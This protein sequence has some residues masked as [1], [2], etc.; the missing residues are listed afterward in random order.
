MT[1][2]TINVLAR[3]LSLALLASTLAFVP[4]ISQVQAQSNPVWA[5]DGVPILMRGGQFNF[6]VPDPANPGELILDQVP[7]TSGI[8][9]ST[10]HDP[11]NGWVYGVVNIGGVRTVR[12]YDA[13]G[14][15]VFNTPIVGDYPQAAG[16]F[17]GTV[18]GDGRYIIHSVGAANGNGW[19]NGNRFNLWAIDPLTG[20]STFIGP[21]PVNFADFSYNP[22]DGFLYQ[23]V[24]RVLYRV[25]PNDGTTT[26]VPTSSVLPN[27]SFGA[28]WFD[29]AG[30][31]HVFRNADGSIWRIDPANPQN[32]V[33]V[34]EVGSN[35]GTDGTNCIS[36][37]DLRKDVVDAAGDAVL[38]QDRVYSVGDVVTYEFTLINNGLPTQNRTVD[39]CDVLPADG[40]VYTGDWTATDPT[41]TL[42]SGGAAGDTNICLEV[43]MPSSLWTDP[44]TPGSP[45]TVVTIDVEIGPGTTPGELQ[46]QATLD[47]DQDGTVDVRSDDPGDGSDPRDPT[48]IEV[49]GSFL[50]SKTVVGHPTDDDSDEFAMTISCTTAS[51]DPFDI[52]A[53]SIVDASTGAAWPGATTNG[54]TI[55][56]GD[57]V[58]VLGL[59]AGTSCTTTEAASTSY[60][61]TVAVT[62]GTPGDG[63]GDDATGAVSTGE[64]T[65][66]IINDNCQ[67]GDGGFV[68]FNL[69]VRNSSGN[70][71][72]WETIWRN[73]PYSVIPNLNAGNY[74]HSVIPAPG[75]L[76]DHVFT[77]TTP[78]GAFGNLAITG[79]VPDPLGSDQGCGDVENFG[80]VTGPASGGGDTGDGGATESNSATLTIDS[81]DESIA[82]TNSTST[83]AIRKGTSV[84]SDLPLDED[85]TFTFD[86][87]CSNGLSETLTITTSGGSDSI[88]Y[89]DTPLVG[90]GV[91]CT[92]S[93][94]VPN[95]WVLT[96]PND[97]EIET[98]AGTIA[99]ATFLNE[100]TFAD[101][102]ISK[103]I[104]GLP[105]GEDPTAFEFDLE[106]R[107]TGGFDPDPYTTSGTFAVGSPLIIEDLPVGAECTVTED[108]VDG[109]NTRYSPQQS[110][111]IASSG[112]DVQVTNSTGSLIIEK[113]TEVASTHPIDP[114]DDFEFTLTCSGPDGIFTDTYSVSADS[115]VADGATG[116]VSHTDV[117]V[118]APGTTC[119]VTETSPAPLWTIDGSDT[120]TLEITEADPEPTATFVNVRNVG[121]LVV[122]KEL[123]GVPA[124]VDLDSEEFI[125]DISCS[126]GFTVD[127][128]LI[129]GQTVSV[130]VP[131]VIDDL[132]TGAECTVTEQ[133]DPRFATTGSPTTVTIDD[134]GEDVLL[135]NTT[136]SFEF[137]KRTASSDIVGT[138]DG[139]FDFAITCTFD[140]VEVASTTTSLTTVGGIAIVDAAGLP[141]VPPGSTCTVTETVPS[142]W[143]ISRRVAPTL[144]GTDGIEF[145]TPLTDDV[146][147]ENTLETET[148]TITKDVLG[149]A[150]T[151]ALEGEVFTI[152][153]ECTGIFPGGT[154]SSG[155]LSISEGAPID[156]DGL[157]LGA[158]CTVAETADG[159]FATTYVPGDSLTIISGDNEVGVENETSTFT[160]SKATV[161]PDGVEPDATFDFAIECI[162]D[163]AAVYTDNITIST[164]AGVGAWDAAPFLPPGT[165]CTVTETAPA[166]WTSVGPGTITIT[167]EGDT[168]VDAAFT[169]E[170]DNADLTIT[171]TLLGDLDGFDFTNEPF[172]AEV[173]CTG[174]FETSPFTTTATVTATT[175]AV[176]PDLPVGAECSVSEVF[177]SRFQTL[178]APE[179]TAGDAAEVTIA[180]GGTEAGLINVAGRLAIRKNT[181]GP[182]SH[183]LGL[184]DDF[185]YTIDCTDGTLITEVANVD[186]L[187]GGQGIGG[188]TYTALPPFAIGTVCTIT[189]TVPPGWT[190]TTPN[191]QTVTIQTDLQTAEFTN[192]RDAGSLTINKTLDGVPTGVDLSNEPFTVT[193]TCTGGG[194]TT[195]PHIIADQIVT[196]S[197]PLVID[198]LPTGAECSA[199]EDSDPR[200]TN[201]VS[202]SV[203]I[204]TDGEV[205]DIV[206]TTSTFSITKTTIGPDTVPVILDDTFEFEVECTSA[207]GDVLFSGTESITT[208]GQTGS[209]AAPDTPLLA[210]GSEC[211]V[212]ELAPPAGW[213]NTSGTTVTITTDSTGSI[214]AA[215][216]NERDTDTLAVTKTITGSPTDLSDEAFIVDISC[217][218]DF[219]TSPHL[220]SGVTLTENTPIAIPDL[221]TGAAC[222][223][224]EQPDAR[225]FA[226]YSPDD[227]I[228][229][230]GE[231]G[232]LVDIDNR[233]GT[234]V[235]EKVV[236]VVGT[237]PIDLSGTFQV[238][239]SCTDGTEF[240]LTLDV[241][242][243]VTATAQ[244]PDVPLLPDGTACT[245]T[246]AGPPTG[247]TLTSG[248]GIEVIV[249]SLGEPVIS[250]TNTRDTGDLNITKT[251]LGAPAGLDVAS[252]TFTVDI[253]C[254]G[255]FTTSPL[256]LSDQPIVNGET[257]TIEDLPT[258]AVCTVIEDPDPRFATTT[259]PVD[260]P[261]TGVTI[262][263]DGED[264]ALVNATGEI[265]IVKNT[266]VS[267]GFP[268]DV[269]ESFDF[270]VDCGAVYSGTHTVVADTITSPTT[271]TG[272]LRYSD[273]PALPN[274]TDC[275]V[276]EQAA[277]TGWTLVSPNPVPLTVDSSGVVTAAF[278]NERDTGSLTIDKTLV[279]VPAITD[280][281]AELFDVTVTCAGGFTAATEVITGQISVDAPLVIPEL[282]T[283]SECAVVETPDARFTTSV[284]P[285][286]TITTDGEEIDVTNTTSTL[287][288]TKTTTGPA[289]QP[290]DLDDTFTFTVECTTATGD[291]LFSG[292]QT[293]TTVDQTGTWATP[294]TPLLPPGTECTISENASTGWTNTSG[295]T[296]TVTTESSDVVD[297]AFENV[298]DTGPLTINKALV[299]V[300]AGTDLDAELFDVTVTC[301]GDF[302]TTT[303]TITG[304][305]SVD[306]PLTITDLPTGATCT[307]I[308]STD[309]RFATSVDGPATIDTDG[310]DVE[311]TNATSTLSITKTTTGPTTHPLDLDDTFAFDTVCTTATGDI[312]FSGTQTITTVDQTG[313]WATP[314]TPLLPPGTECTVTEQTPPTGWTNTSGT[315][316]T[317]TTESSD[318]VDAAFIN[319]RDTETLT[320]NK[321]LLGVPE[322]I[323]LS[324]TPFD[325]TVTCTT[326]FTTTEHTVNGQVSSVAPLEIPDL[327]TGAECE[328]EEA[329]DARFFTTYT[330]ANDTGDAAVTTITNGEN[331]VQV[332]NSTGA[333][334]VSKDT[335]VPP[336]H[337]IDPV[338]EFT[339]TIDCGAVYSA[340]HT[341]T[342]DL[343]T[344]T[345]AT[346]VIFYTDLP[347]IPEGTI[348]NVTE[349]D[350]TPEWTLTTDRTVT[351][352]ASSENP[353]TAQFVNERTLGTLDINKII[354]GP[355]EVD[356][357]AET[358]DITVTCSNGFTEDPYVL[359]GVIGEGTPFTIDDLPYGAECDTAESAD[360][361]FATSYSS[362]QGEISSDVTITTEPSIVDVLNQTGSFHV[363]IGTLVSSARPFDPDDEF[364]F[365]VTCSNNDEVIYEAT[366]DATTEDG[367]FRFEAALLPTGTTCETTLDS[368]SEW[369]TVSAMGEQSTEMAITQ[370]I[371]TDIAWNAFEVERATASLP[372]NKE[373]AGLPA[374]TDFAT[375][376]FAI[377]VTCVGG[378]IDAEHQLTEDLLVSTTDPLIVPE[379][380]V[381]SEC[382][383]VEQASDLFDDSYST[384]PTFVVS[385]GDSDNALII[386]NT[387]TDSL[388]SSLEPDA[389]PLAFTGSTVWPLV[390]F[391]ILLLLAGV[392]IIGPRRRRDEIEA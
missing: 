345:G 18:L 205:I 23:P 132:P 324:A 145:T 89:P 69:Q 265:M 91:T 113:F 341:I 123:A 176:V 253:V 112:T 211:T 174:D 283:G 234:F 203:T 351:L 371:G 308:E 287:S 373:L 71:I 1:S 149:V 126:G 340:D 391:A 299:G 318:I 76:F 65:A 97:V 106:V 382:T 339:F 269:T 374:D 22:L 243:G 329:S 153:V 346:G 154:Y 93:E 233:T 147:F 156:I 53:T 199:V 261:T 118:I 343:L 303:H 49:L 41:A 195:D 386:T 144:V 111:E 170:R 317:V 306:S 350:E 163:G 276:T 81:G 286:A 82:F 304:Q 208:L 58:E 356:L 185:T 207:T 327:P 380:P 280:L 39:L 311:I 178:Y 245:A 193:V 191:P 131:L 255:D 377:D 337:P 165:V 222:T 24:N 320:V 285:D 166:G 209:W 392:L 198:D 296:A 183:P 388:L 307:A 231:N 20:A 180:D 29:S 94:D 179:N 128:Y 252:L 348:C 31:L 135:T 105:D 21:T 292:T 139:T 130:A 312:L 64:P 114:V 336:T 378:F 367:A 309:A 223:V 110:V 279:G 115:L 26:T 181:L 108:P 210:P 73:R 368:P 372:I 168:V 48:T 90:D 375:E 56:N 182:A 161:V 84:T 83:L 295:I 220:I 32:V 354:E 14:D 363:D 55:A 314:A 219:T 389:P 271:A 239:V 270:A 66:S 88:Q 323:D 194:L 289:T 281:D 330:P 142:G 213:T 140:G 74:I 70:S 366:V 338:D 225:F 362:T 120:Q 385:A 236:D 353:V 68:P 146:G 221:P 100:R 7:G 290:L 206:N 275:T 310:E 184:L 187:S 349:L 107:C 274:G 11:I 273:L 67:D 129:S 99:G 240:S 313:T 357:S 62:D 200:F 169:N 8:A 251:V 47:F 364:T 266:Q 257:I 361:R 52:Q 284:G 249:N 122:T 218:G 37:I 333:V 40:R 224:V 160:I 260:A 143:T 172:T 204:D 124:T 54:F 360:A 268:V 119:E 242:G 201:S 16:Q 258:G 247:W 121:S 379:L 334:I 125:V 263:T 319:D 248:N 79:G 238:D 190:V 196:A 102:T 86:L 171:K 78:L 272:F 278:T 217:T 332:T 228:A 202:D 85:G 43:D 42:T 376:E 229:V 369:N 95:G 38:P 50:V 300:P 335:V 237:Q 214:D 46:N 226:T 19:F 117:G 155:P 96:S 232:S 133:A 33:Q 87:S 216:E 192:E 316:T 77:G 158:E 25:D 60:T 59:S 101:L 127:P 164:V 244:L 148:L 352:T 315:T 301:T 150:A 267:S 256:V 30:N 344:P 293:I 264:V 355:V 51:G 262:D 321:V 104:L 137:Q 188:I 387:A 141:L 5:C 359:T 12:A 328:V 189:E 331:A 28:S 326:G 159:R 45:P 302:E 177:D 152:S 15:I 250:F 390:W 167:T 44:A 322:D 2:R 98:V 342:T 138:I 17:A 381:G 136:S 109:F 230:I 10:A 358:F 370:T 383:V 80:G 13:N 197:T 61:A 34:G 173:T 241:V 36:S 9:N 103:I 3:A 186:Q 294:A 157:P 259:T 212:T 27:G 347:L 116:G 35:G 63:D 134:D 291:I 305:F 288:I 246:E 57:D 162:A 325:I 4:F 277:P 384:S 175:P 298:R 75:G 151:P 235:V 297:A 92:I 282:P 72:D 227:G 365:I 215:F 254:T 6:V